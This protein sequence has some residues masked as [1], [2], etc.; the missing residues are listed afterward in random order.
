MDVQVSL[1]L[2]RESWVEN[3]NLEIIRLWTALNSM[4]L[5]DITNSLSLN[6][7]DK[8]FQDGVLGHFNFK[9]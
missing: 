2:E 3:V 5:D 9:R 4:S 1:H 7:E 6:R 8:G